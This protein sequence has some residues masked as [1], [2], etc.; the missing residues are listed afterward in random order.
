M[1]SALSI[2]NIC[3]VCGYAPEE[4]YEDH[5]I[6]VCCGTQFGYHDSIRRHAEIREDWLS[7]GAPWNSRRK[8]MTEG[9][10][11][12]EQMKDAGLI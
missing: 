6:C 1:S 10:D 11:A 3:P 4:A 8:A 5:D 2:Y 12:Q 7:R 9:W